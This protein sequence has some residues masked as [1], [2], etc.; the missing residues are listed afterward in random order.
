MMAARVR[1]EPTLRIDQPR[2]LFQGQFQLGSFW[3]EY[4]VSPTTKDFLMVAVDEPT[5]PRLAVA[6]NFLPAVADK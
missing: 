3:S 6:M 1:T 4:D 5:R 2:T